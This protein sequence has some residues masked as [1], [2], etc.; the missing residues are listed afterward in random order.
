MDALQATAAT[1][2]P[3]AT[4]ATATTDTSASTGT[5]KS[6]ATLYAE[7]TK[8]LQDGEKLTAVDGH[9]YARIKGGD[10]DEMCVNL[11]GNGRNGKA[12]DLITRD[13]RQFHVYGGTGADHV[14]VEVGKK[15]AT[16]TT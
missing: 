8:D 11:S 9:P 2:A 13:G 3:I 16:T 1:A 12:F 10:R 6:F 14:V 5:T 15:A 4:T 7:A